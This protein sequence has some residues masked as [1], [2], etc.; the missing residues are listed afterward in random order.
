MQLG[1]DFYTLKPD[2]KSN[3]NLFR[4]TM[5]IKNIA[6]REKTSSKGLFF[7]GLFLENESSKEQIKFFNRS[8]NKSFFVNALV[9]VS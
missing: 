4:A 7:L 5:L 1:F 3:V 2:S 9:L 6:K 8:F